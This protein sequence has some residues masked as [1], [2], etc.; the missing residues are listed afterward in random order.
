MSEPGA[1]YDRLWTDAYGEMQR[2]GPVHRHVRRMLGELLAGLEYE[3]ALEVGC[4]AGDNF[5]VLSERGRAPRLTGADVSEQALERARRAWPDVELHRLDIEAGRLEG[6]WEL[7]LCSLVLEHLSDDRAALRNIR[8][9]AAGQLVVATIGGDISRYQPWEER[10]GHL[11]NYGPGELEAKL[12]EAGFAVE[13]SIRWGYPF[14]S[15]LARRLLRR[16]RPSAELGRGARF[17]AAVLHELYRLNSH[18]RGELL[19]VR[20]TAT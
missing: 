10:V 3:S 20:A 18:R 12:V 9:M 19:L 14:Y 13:R 17:A 1:E 8:S 11:R 15:P 6:Q 4:G 7:I 16:M 5:A 2:V